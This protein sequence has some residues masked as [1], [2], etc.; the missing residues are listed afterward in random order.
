MV[1]G[2]DGDNEQNYQGAVVSVQ[3]DTLPASKDPCGSKQNKSCL[4]Q[5]IF[6]EKNRPSIPDNSPYNQTLNL[7]PGAWAW[8]PDQSTV[9][10]PRYIT[11]DSTWKA[12]YIYSSDWLKPEYNDDSWP[13]AWDM[14]PVESWAK[15]PTKTDPPYARWLWAAQDYN[16]VD[17]CNSWSWFSWGCHSNCNSYFPSTG[18]VFL[19]KE[20]ELPGNPVTATVQIAGDDT[21]TFYVDGIA[22]ENCSKDCSTKLKSIQLNNLHKGTNAIA[23]QA[24]NFGGPAGVLV[25]IKI[26]FYETFTFPP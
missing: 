1:G 11:S 10:M 14:P 2:S 21:Y 20:I 13:Y 8:V 4:G 3:L 25:I 7:L 16:D 24:S 19:R 23:I 9:L 6:S 17:N 26:D 5:W 12:N 15:P 22:V 18:N